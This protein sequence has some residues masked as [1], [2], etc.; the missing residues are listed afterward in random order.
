MEDVYYRPEIARS[1]TVTDHYVLFVIDKFGG[2]KHIISELTIV[3]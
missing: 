1:I 2:A 3:K